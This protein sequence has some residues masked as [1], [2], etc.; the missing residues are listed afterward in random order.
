VLLAAGGRPI[1]RPPAV[2]WRARLR[3]AGGGS[4]EERRDRDHR[5][6]RHQGDIG[7]VEGDQEV[8]DATLTATMASTAR[9]GTDR[10]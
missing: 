6:T 10:A 4:P 2:S 3:V 1:G 9:A 8:A 5:E 7:G